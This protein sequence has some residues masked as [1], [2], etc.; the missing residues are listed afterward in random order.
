ME[1]QE[2][3]QQLTLAQVLHYYHLK[4]NKQLQLNCPFHNDKT[5]SM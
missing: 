3:K 4:P 2:I 5:P 1:I